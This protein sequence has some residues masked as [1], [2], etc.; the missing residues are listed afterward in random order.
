MKTGYYIT[1]A[2]DYVNAAPHLGHA[3]EKIATDVMARFMR[4]QGGPVFFLTGTDEH[5]SKVQK[6]AQSQGLEPQAFTNGIADQFKACWQLM[7]VAYDRFIRTTDAAHYTLVAH[8]WQQLVAQGDIYKHQY[9]GQY[10]QGCETFLTA[11]DLTPDGK[12]HIHGTTPETVVEENYFFKLTRY[13]QQLIDHIAANP[14]YILP[15]F[16]LQEVLNTLDELT[17]ISVSRSSVA[18][19]I[20]VPGDPEQTIYV[21]IDALSNYLTGV[22][23]FNAQGQFESAHWPAAVHVIG[24]DILRFHAIYW[25]CILMAV[26]LPLPQHIMAH[27]FINLNDNK[28][29]KSSGNVVAPADV[30]NAFNL[31]QPDALRY[32]L[33]VV[34][35]FGQDGNFTLDDFKTRVNADLA[36]NLGNLLNR[37]MAMTQKFHQGQVPAITDEGLL[38]TPE[39]T[40]MLVQQVGQAYEQFAFQHAIELTLQRVDAANKLINQHEPW[41]LHKEG[42]TEMLARVMRTVLEALR[43]VAILLAPVV[44]NLAAAMWQQLGYTTPLAQV[45]WSAALAL[46]LPTGQVLQPGEPLFLRLD[47]DIAGKA[48]KQQTPS[49]AAS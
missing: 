14:R 17:D 48:A 7:D 40:A 45:P 38:F 1:T 4:M 15:E 44:P 12:C 28:I 3:Y 13:K 42:N 9:E 35:A 6:T 16:R 21:W 29:S 43:L 23:H 39:E 49:K 25:S 32:Y 37:A 46:S 47:S 20:P 8:L 18:W 11:R 30:L 24:K 41:N 36:N 19:G 27:G 26:G 34:T 5:G 31:T 22:G 33:M 2:I 10:C